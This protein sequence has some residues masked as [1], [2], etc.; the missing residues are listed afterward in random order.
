MSKVASL[1]HLRAALGDH[2]VGGYIIRI[3]LLPIGIKGGGQCVLL[4]LSEHVVRSAIDAL[5]RYYN[6]L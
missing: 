1:N 2:L 3:Q 6:L 4:F 5:R